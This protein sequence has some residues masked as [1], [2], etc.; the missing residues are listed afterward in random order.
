[1]EA[2]SLEEHEELVESSFGLISLSELEEARVECPI[3]IDPILRTHGLRTA[4][5]HLFH[6]ECLERW[7]AQTVGPP[8]LA[9]LP[10]R[11]RGDRLFAASAV[12]LLNTF[13]GRPEPFNE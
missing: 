8:S 2:V 3:C 7:L 10:G 6:E 1:M 9:S 5:G 4:C 13:R 12:C 11:I